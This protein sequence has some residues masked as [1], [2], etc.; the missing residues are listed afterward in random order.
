MK[1]K[2]LVLLALFIA[3]SFIGANLKIAESIAFDSMAAFL[4]ALILG[5][6][7]GA[8][9]GAAGHLL[10]A[11]TSGFP[12]SVPVHLIIMVEMALTMYVFGSLY[13]LFSKKN[14]TLATIL[15]SIVA[16]I[17]NGPISVLILIPIMGIGIAAMIPVLSFDAFLNVFIA[18]LIYNLLPKSIKQWK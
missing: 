13:K 12:Y 4:G 6:K 10:S 2:T 5:P 14:I 17:L 15:S 7:Y 1:T 11:I 9:I 3:I 18:F 16:V 8:I